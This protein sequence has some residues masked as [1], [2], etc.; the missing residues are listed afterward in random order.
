VR[1]FHD[2]PRLAG[3]VRQKHENIDAVLEQFVDLAKLQVIVAIGGAGDDGASEFMGALLKF[4]ELGLL[5]LAPFMSSMED[6]ILI[7]GF[8]ACAIASVRTMRTKETPV[9]K[10]DEARM[11]VSPKAAALR[12]IKTMRA[13]AR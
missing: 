7:S 2:A 3:I 1:R 11:K 8:C 4:V 9:R 13:E 12:A 5:T 10:R 6:P